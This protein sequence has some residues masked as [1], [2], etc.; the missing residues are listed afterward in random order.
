VL[1][2]SVCAASFVGVLRVRAVCN[3]LHVA[4]QA[5]IGGI[6]GGSIAGVVC[7]VV[8]VLVFLRWRKAQV[9]VKGG[10][11]REEVGVIRSRV[12]SP[13]QYYDPDTD[14]KKNKN[15]DGKRDALCCL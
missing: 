9:C 4:A 11:G 7:I 5:T 8:L 1:W 14:T 13:K 12:I 15:T 6:V 2:C 3:V 10:V